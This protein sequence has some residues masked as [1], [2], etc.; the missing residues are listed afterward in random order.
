MTLRIVVL[1]SGAGS[2]FAA[3]ADAIDAGR[4]DA[5]I[6]AVISDRAAAPGLAI[7]T[8]RDLPTVVVSP[9]SYADRAAWDAA[10]A[11]A[12]A[13]FSPDLIVLAGFMRLLGAPL[14]ARCPRRV[15]NVH[16]SLLPLFPGTTGP[17]QALAANVRISGCTVHLVDHGVDTGPIIAQAAVRVLPDDT[18]ATLHAR[19]QRAE[20]TLLPRVVDAIARGA[21][22]LDPEVRLHA[23]A[24]DGLLLCSPLFAEAQS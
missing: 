18:A 14:L 21:V 6:A 13:G 22:T 11:D 2:N 1:I 23:A 10:L 4:C 20:H 17:E 8:A 16:P 3:L 5:S 19:I 15:I 12:V 7:A 24:D 9:K